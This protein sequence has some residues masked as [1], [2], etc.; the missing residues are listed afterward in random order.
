MDEYSVLCTAADEGVE[1]ATEAVMVRPV[2]LCEQHRIQVA[3]LVVPDALA[4]LLRQAR[5]DLP[6]KAIQERFGVSQATASRMRS[7][8]GP[9]AGNA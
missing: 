9:G 8:A 2:P 4:T 7:E 1:C 5:T 3:L 6:L